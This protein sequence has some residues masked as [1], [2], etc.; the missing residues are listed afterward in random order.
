MECSKEPAWQSNR[1][2]EETNWRMLQDERL[3]DVTFLV[4]SAKEEKIMAHRF[5]L[6]SRSPVFFTMF[7]GSLPET[8]QTIGVP[9]IEPAIF[10]DMLRYFTIFY[11]NLL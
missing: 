9:D 7:C 5:I 11:L 4:G 6:A 2:F 1:L 3:C 8:S 10:R